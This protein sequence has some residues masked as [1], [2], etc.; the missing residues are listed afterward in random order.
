M[1]RFGEVTAQGQKVELVGGVSF[2]N[3]YAIFE[4]RLIQMK[5]IVFTF[6]FLLIGTIS[7]ASISACDKK[8]KE[9][10]P[11]TTIDGYI[12]MPDGSWKKADDPKPRKPESNKNSNQ[13]KDM[14][15]F[16]L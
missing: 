12:C 13:E 9:Y 4:M 16:L 5:V 7:S 10:P 11:G 6:F 1:I 3:E 8:G 2:T 14:R 15:L